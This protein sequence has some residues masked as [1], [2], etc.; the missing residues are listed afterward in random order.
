M[1]GDLRN[2]QTWLAVGSLMILATVALA[3]ALVYTRDVMIPFVLAIFI[4][5]AVAPVV[6]V[7]VTRL[8]L[9]GWFAVVTTLFLVLVALALMGV[10]LIM[11]VQAIVRVANQYSEQ[12][13]KLTDQLFEELKTH[14]IQVEPSRISAELEARLPGVISQTVGTAT[15][16]VAHGFL[17]VFFV[18]F[19]LLGR[20]PL[21]KRTGIY[22]DIESTIRS[23]ITTMTALSAMTSVL[24]G[25]VLWALGLQMA[26]LFA[27]LV[28][29]LCYIPNIG[30]I[31]ATIL[32]VPVAVAQF[33]DP[34]MILATVAIPGAI[35]M[36]IGN[37]VAPK[38]MGRGMELHP[39]TVLLALAFWGLLWGIVGMVLAM[40]IVAT[41]R[42]ILARFST[43]RPLANLLAGQLPGTDA[44]VTTLTAEI[45]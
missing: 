29:L 26:W 32:P 22:A 30:S 42:I 37:F 31:I 35:H 11:A 28:F 24:V 4:T 10:V 36:T 45:S 8:R 12:V 41:L 18:I 6:D 3:T 40:P 43:T 9:P 7:Q 13:I 15:T 44:D 33:H 39:V 23:Y 16:F 27:F 20:H 14:N 19:L 2:E 5:T 25:I 21:L 1:D 17:I 38:M 34:W